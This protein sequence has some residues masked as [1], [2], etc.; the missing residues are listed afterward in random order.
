[1]QALRKRWCPTAVIFVVLL[2]FFVHGVTYS[3]VCDCPPIA[4]A[5]LVTALR[6]VVVED[7]P[8]YFVYG[9]KPVLIC[10]IIG[11]ERVGDVIPAR[12]CGSGEIGLLHKDEALSVLM[13]AV[14]LEFHFDFLHFF[15]GSRPADLY[16]D[17]IIALQL[18]NVNSF[19]IFSKRKKRLNSLFFLLA[20]RQDL[21][22]Y[23]IRFNPTHLTR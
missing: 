7:I 5:V 16:L 22:G 15:W 12:V 8:E 17:C 23:Y 1:M 11:A 10:L 2:A 6:V 20:S 19:F 3:V 14:M 18:Y 21:F 4:G 9:D 13:F